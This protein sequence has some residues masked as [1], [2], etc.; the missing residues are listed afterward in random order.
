MFK[1]LFAQKHTIYILIFVRKIFMY[2]CIRIFKH[3]CA[4]T[5]AFFLNPLKNTISY[6]YFFT[7]H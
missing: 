4:K 6:Y 2:Y 3:I 1:I 7:K 5:I